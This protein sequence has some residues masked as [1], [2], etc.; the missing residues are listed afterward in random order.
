MAVKRAKK[1]TNPEIPV[2]SQTVPSVPTPAVPVVPTPTNPAPTASA[3]KPKKYSGFLGAGDTIPAT[4][5]LNTRFGTYLMDNNQT[6]YEIGHSAK[7]NRNYIGICTPEF[8]TQVRRW[9]GVS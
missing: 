9:A 4:Q 2:I 3:E 8:A 7:T 5:I 1:V 6:V